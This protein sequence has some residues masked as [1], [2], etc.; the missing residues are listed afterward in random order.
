MD[1]AG[2][3]LFALTW[4]ARVTPSRRL[5][6]ALR[7]SGRRISGSVYGSWPS[8]VVNDSKGSDYA[9]SQGN[10]DRLVLKLGGV[11]KLAHWTTPNVNEQNERPEVK[12]ARNARHRQAGK[13]KGV[14]SYKLGNAI[15]PQVA[16]AFIESYL[17]AT[18]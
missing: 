6:S 13:M 8:P 1:S 12:D 7:A 17:E 15:V 9:Y 14:G 10:H 18:A 11:A 2:S 3:T 16:Q 4:K 5:I